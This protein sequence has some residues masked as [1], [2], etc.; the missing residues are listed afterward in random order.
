MT[1][2]ILVYNPP[3]T[4]DISV[5]EAAAS[6]GALGIL[7]LEYMEIDS[8]K[9]ILSSL[10]SKGFPFGIRADPTGE[11][12]MLL[13]GDE[14]P[15]TLR[16]LV[17]ISKGGMGEMIRKSIYETASGMGIE[18]VQEVCDLEEADE[19][20]R[21]GIGTIVVRGQGSGG[22]IGSLPEL[23]FASKVKTSNP[24]VKVL[25]MGDVGLKDMDTLV[26]SGADGIVLD[27]QVVGFPDRMEE[28]KMRAS[29]PTRVVMA[30]IGK[31]MRM[32]MG[33]EGERIAAI[34]AQLASSGAGG[35]ERY[36]AVRSEIASVISSGKDPFVLLGPGASKHLNGL[37]EIGASGPTSE[38]ATP[39]Q[40]VPA[41]RERTVTVDG[42]PV[43][44]D[45]YDNAVAIIGLGSVFPRGI[46]NDN[47]WRMVLDGVDACTEVPPERWDW[48]LHYDPDP[49]VPY[50]TYS[51]IGAFIK[52]FH[53]DY[54][55]FK[56]PPKAFDQFDLFQRYAI[57]A[58]KEALID[59]NIFDRKDL[60]RDRIGCVIANASG[61]ERRDWVALRT[62]FEELESWT[63][64]MEDWKAFPEDVRE[65]MLGTIRKALETNVFD[66]DEDTMPGS[67]PNISSG[68]LANMFDLRG[69]NFITDAACASTIAAIYSSINQL[70][71]NHID[72]GVT[73]GTD[74][75]HNSH[76]YIEFCKIGALTPDGSRPFS[77]GANGFLMGE[78]AG[79]IVLKRIEDAVRDNDRI[80]AVIK[81]IAGSSDGK[82]K[83][84]TAPNPRG[85]TS[86]VKKALLDAK[87]DRS[88]ISFIE[89]HGTSTI[90]GDVAELASLQEVFGGLPKGT[91][92]LTSVKSQIGHLKAAAGAPGMIKAALAIHNKVLPPQINFEKPNR[93]FDWEKS[94]FYVI[95][96]TM[97]WKRIAQDTPRRC[98]VSSFGFGGTNFHVVMEEF[99]PTIYSAWKR[100]KEANPRKVQEASSGP[101]AP[102]EYDM[103]KISEYMAKKGDLVS[104]VFFFDSD[105]PLNMLK[106]AEEA[107]EEARSAIRLR[108][109]WKRPEGKGRY[110]LAIVAKDAAHFA[111]QIAMLKKVGMNE[112]ALMA[113]AAKGI[114]VGDRERIRNRKTCLMFPGQGSQYINMFRDLSE[115][116]SIVRDAF[117]EAD[118]VMK[119]YIDD[120]LSS[121]V[122]RDVELGTSE[123]KEAQATLTRTEFNQPAMLTADTAMYKLLRS[124]GVEPDIVMGH[125]LGE[126]GALI[127]S[128]ALSFKD[129][130]IAVSARGREMRDL[131]VEDPGKM[132]SIMAGVDEVEKVLSKIDGYVIAANKNCYIQTVIAGESAAMDEAVA[133]F[134]EM[135]IE[136]QFIP[137][138][139]AFHSAVVAPVRPILRNYLAKLDFRTPAIPILANIDGD[140]YPGGGDPDK[141][142]ER[143]LD[144]LEEQV[145]ASVEWI[146]QVQR[147]HADGCNVFIESGPKRALSTFV[148]NILEEKVKKGE[149]FPVTSNHPKKGGIFSFNEMLGSLWAIGYD[150]KFPDVNDET[151]FDPGF[152]H[153]LDR[154]SK[155]REAPIV[156]PPVVIETPPAPPPVSSSAPT[157]DE[158]MRENARA[159][160]DFLKERF[161]SYV[162]R[163]GTEAPAPQIPSRV[164]ERVRDRRRIVVT[165]VSMGLP[166]RFKKV[167]SEDNF[168]LLIQGRDLIGTID[169]SRR[170][171][172][173]EK[174]IVRLEKRPDGSAEMIKLDDDSMIAHLAGLL[175]DFDPVSEFGIPQ[176]IV[177]DLDMTSKLAFAAGLLALRDAGIPLVRRYSQ[178]TTGSYLPEG[179]ELPQEL[180]E[181]TGIIFA[182]SFPGMNNVFRNLKEFYKDKG[183]YTMPRHIMFQILAMAHSQFAQY[184]KAKGPNTQVNSACASTTLAIAIAQ[185]WISTGRCKR[186]IVLGADDPANDD[187]IEWLGSS[188]LAL[189]ALTTEKDVSKAAVP[190][191]RRRSGM[192]VGSGA[193]GLVLES[194]EGPRRRG[195]TPIVEVLG[196]HIG[197]SA[198]H[199]SRLDIPHIA[200]SMDRFITKMEREH[201]LRREE[202][203]PDLIFMSHETYTPAR[204]GSSAAEVESLRRT[205]GDRF[206]DILIMNTKGFTG[207]A[208]GCCIEDPA[209]L[210]SIRTGRAIPI[211]N[212]DPKNIDPQFEGLNLSNGGNHERRYGLRLAA[213]FGSQLAFVLF[214][215][216]SLEEFPEDKARYGSWLRAIATTE[217]V[218]LE[219]VQNVLRLRDGGISNLIHYRAIRRESAEIGF[220]RGEASNIPEEK[221]SRFK[222]EILRI[223]SEKTGIAVELIDIDADLDSDLGIDSVKQVELFAAARTAFD[224]P[225][226]EGVNLRDYPT[227]RKVIDYVASKSAWGQVDID[228]APTPS[229]SNEIE[230]R[231][232]EIVSEKTGYS[233]DMLDLDLD[234]EAD[235]GIDTV[236]QVELFASARG[237]FD[238]PRDDTVNLK[239]F[240]TLRHIIDY[241][242]SRAK[243]EPQSKPGKT[244]QPSMESQ[245]DL[246]RDR[247]VS[248]VAEKTGYP[249][250]MLELDLD[251]EADLGID[252]VKQVE[253]FASARGE[254]DLP[255]DDTVNLKDFPTLRHI[256][257]YVSSR[258]KVE[259]QSKP[260]EAAQPS[261]ESQADLIRDRIVSIVA[262]KTG[263][264]LDM[265]ELDLD[266]E[267]DLG[268]DTVK[269]VELFA[270][271]R[272][273]FDLPRDDAVNL[274]DF[275]TLRHIIDYVTSRASMGS[276]KSGDVSK[277]ASVEELKQSVNRWVL[278]ADPAP[279]IKDA[280]PRPL[281][282]KRLLMLGNASP[283]LIREKLGC[284]VVRVTME[285]VLMER[286][287]I[288]DFHGMLDL[289]ILDSSFD[290]LKDDWKIET[291]RVILPLF[292][293][294][295]GMH[296]VLKNGGTFVTVTTMGGRFGTDRPV[297]PLNGAVSGFT[298]AL[299]REYPSSQIM[300]FDVRPDLEKEALFENLSLE[301]GVSDT[302][303]EVGWDGRRFIPAL[304]IITP[305][306]E[307]GGIRNGMRILISGGGTGI[308]SEIARGLADRAKLDLHLMGRTSLPK[309]IKEL[310]S[311]DEKGMA[312][313]KDRIKEKLKKGK[314]K[315]TPVMLEREYS[316]LEKAISI[317][318]LIEDIERRGSVAHYHSVDVTDAKAVSKIVKHAGE[319]NGVIHAAGI[320]QSKLLINKTEEDFSRVVDTKIVGAANIIE[321]TKDHPLEFFVSFSSVAGRFGNAGQ[322]DYS[323]AN[324]MLDKMWG[325][326]RSLHPDCL[327]KAVGWSAWADVGMASRGS[328]KTILEIG[329]VTFI[330]IAEGVEYAIAEMIS[331]REKEVFYAGSMGPLDNEGT[332]R[333]SE[334]V[335]QPY[336]LGISPL[337][338]SMDTKDEINIFRRRLD[339]RREIFLN[340]HRIMNVPVLPGAMGVEMFSEAAQRVLGSRV[341]LFDVK[342]NRPVNVDPFLDVEIHTKEDGS[343]AIEMELVSG[344]EDKRVIHFT[345]RARS[346]KKEKTELIKGHPI[347]PGTVLARISAKEIYPH[348]FLD[349]LFHVLSGAEVL[350]DGEFLGVY[351]PVK[352]DLIDPGYG[353]SNADMEYSPMHVELGFQ[354]SGAY[355]LDKFHMVALPISVGRMMVI[356]PLPSD[357]RAL[358]WV[359]FKGKEGKAYNFDVDIIDLQGKV[360]ISYR[361]Y[362]LAGLM[363]TENDIVPDSDY[364]FDTIES[365]DASIS[366]VVVDIEA[367][368]SDLDHYQRCFDND[369][370]GLIRKE[371]TEKRAREHL[372]G[373]LAG[374]AAVAL[375]LSVSRGIY[376]PVREVQILAEKGGKPYAVVRGERIEI[377]ISHSRRWALG[378]VSEKIHGSDIESSEPRDRS[379]LDE[380][381][382]EQEM[383]LIKKLTKELPMT[384]E[385]AVNIFFSSK[386]ALLKMLGLGLSENLR[387]VSVKAAKKTDDLLSMELTLRYGKDKYLVGTRMFGAYVVS[388]CKE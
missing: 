99:D 28:A 273:E 94:P 204:G 166:G 270:S 388:T 287:E 35:K 138:S 264:P 214:K 352:G 385:L 12:M 230:K 92:G 257:D 77:D 48:R 277:K 3:S 198:F 222:D 144:I 267:A 30:D 167:F 194:E 255:R 174:N 136:A 332:M 337:L 220:E 135:G 333:W 299:K 36:K 163:T 127:A 72:I 10:G 146:K 137:V 378:S 60:D 368:R 281:E 68:R 207:H 123:Y 348:L 178:T 260:G 111:D 132:A 205:F 362:S 186:V 350:G 293:I 215:K 209:L 11:K 115:K 231:I 242:S 282:G 307:P 353:F 14:R 384:E 181:D 386:E 26:R 172:I 382:T 334:G 324:D 320:E 107:S 179:F 168:D 325:T 91:I 265:L 354:L 113:L 253:L 62:M 199:G 148:Y 101:G 297:N 280:K 93:Y 157:F 15:T 203:A 375:H 59:A 212:L 114:F 64:S 201:G 224:L 152:L 95:T 351:E 189:G 357:E 23:D 259:P 79:T 256:I 169:P 376:V 21:S 41:M 42:R 110:R 1:P 254:F 89:A 295:K 145:A 49:S 309:D 323:A 321:A 367:L 246:I 5:M 317:Y 318:R 312:E 40:R 243:V 134:K 45:Y 347:R 363:P 109:V 151:F 9:R 291:D 19:S 61:G 322:A 197:N 211:A 315:V 301:L 170:E 173:L 298:K 85:Q 32:N 268:I 73:G 143:M 327:V 236:K 57:R 241:V 90:V 160:E 240:P 313:R 340:D 306:L 56:I 51:K 47:F 235:L 206:K 25:V 139:H 311:L 331:G 245:A 39:V 177:E 355:I 200:R 182:S 6:S 346:M 31:G 304:R 372:A 4:D 373:R 183:S 379:F 24:N 78:G 377:S 82:G 387:K 128:G 191:D 275:P 196:S 294:A 210:M 383:K 244:A 53:M 285:D 208:F 153:A 76:V 44:P 164:V 356:E 140:Y 218:E 237:E 105:D 360:R 103:E 129:A 83:G 22:R 33:G 381:F 75:G 70:N 29:V 97:E 229:P 150:L 66:I 223:F 371:M 54:K 55:E 310:A 116:Y 344:P 141:V 67:L 247:I 343:G 284:E 366:L 84:I 8:I 16:M 104:E 52:D 108:D 364:P 20:A 69:P 175:G 195:M 122:F 380:A 46:G 252:T 261:M 180:Q 133:K 336:P 238:L 74:S 130:L 86:S 117:F 319:I 37:E 216:T 213:G 147:A 276:E 119:D 185:D 232:V 341:E 126:Y 286:V 339:G 329:G 188:L 106:L 158:F 159:F 345:A 308:T 125:S 65:N 263:Y 316:K 328:V 227:L 374:K 87:V 225:K 283:D 288:S 18:V 7:D 271:A 13:M 289:S 43:P 118:A 50:K 342:F 269:Q 279:A 17:C 98:G 124:Y 314:D 335:H 266:L 27:S 250:D 154:F 303:P 258:A 370:K 121:Y 71:L 63:R 262:E 120:P 190:F 156:S 102:L 131:P 300:V 217:P 248:I 80:Y 251:L 171:R 302:P 162:G 149:V 338:D 274:K 34:D 96:K 88:T 81:G 326:V 361:D 369:W 349:E 221:F 155:P 142:K 202:L 193:V 100:V 272:G 292:R 38:R 228:T 278:Q 365:S 249:L 187:S 219:V 161:E 184:I 165:G 290:P 234:L 330:P 359:R 58:T 305:S 296:D 233:P 2:T 112:K 192:I 226:D 176:N 239:D 358:A